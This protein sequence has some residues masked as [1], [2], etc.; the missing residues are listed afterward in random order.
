MI[1]D[2]ISLMLLHLEI[3]NYTLINQICA[4]LSS[5]FN[6]ITGEIGVGKSIILDALGLLLGNRSDSRIAPKNKK[7]HYRSNL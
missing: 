2:F 6:V 5:G 3:R 4:Y 7:M 1:L